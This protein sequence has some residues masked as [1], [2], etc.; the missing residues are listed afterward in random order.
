M[1]A[2][3]ADGKTETGAVMQQKQALYIL[4]GTLLISLI[5]TIGIA[6]PYPVLAPYFLDYP[7]NPLNHFLGIH[8]K[9]LLGFTLAV[10]PFGMLIGSVFIGALSDRYGRRRVLLISLM[11]TFFG[12]LLTA[13]AFVQES[14]VAFTLARLLTGVAQGNVSIA[15][16]VA[17]DLHPH[18]NR[19]RA[20]SLVYAANYAGWLIGPLL[21]GLL[22][23]YGVPL[24][25]IVAG[26][27]VLSG[28]W[29]VWW[30]FERDG[31]AAEAHEGGFWHEIRH[32][33]SMIL[34]KNP[35]LWPFCAFYVL[36][37]LGLNAFYEFYPVWMVDTLASD[38]FEIARATLS[39]TVSM[40][41]VSTFVVDRLQASLGEH[42]SMLY[43]ALALTALLFTQPLVETW[44]H[45]MFFLIGAF[46]A[47][48]NN[49][50]PAY[51]SARFSALGLGKVMG[52]HT[53]LFFI[54]NILIA[55]IGGFLSVL[56]SRVVLWLGAALVLTSAGVL[57][58]QRQHFSAEPAPL[59]VDAT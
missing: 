21:G 12:Y 53:S 38:S 34:L 29:V 58:W 22:M 55:L 9:I 8:P 45:P 25:F 3:Y 13:L 27:G 35:A 42:K 19:T 37:A 43:G 23:P 54:C 14:F 44:I 4:F 16:A 26:V 7:A 48:A 59:T 50:I 6:L 15:R 39:L 10:Y 40:I 18:I 17:A 56:G 31:R 11:A 20:L 52:L 41:L 28:W 57:I 2:V 5:G 1:G 33:N 24:V 30:I 49:M 32:N 51:L 46:N 36:F 47:M